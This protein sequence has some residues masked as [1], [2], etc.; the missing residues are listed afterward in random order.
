MDLP[1]FGAHVAGFEQ[2]EE[3]A[4]A[5]QV[6]HLVPVADRVQAVR[7]VANREPTPAEAWAS[8]A[9]DPAGFY[10]LLGET[11]GLRLEAA[12]DTA[13]RRRGADPAVHFWQV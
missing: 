1:H 13:P 5:E 11:I 4:V 2:A 3:H 12:A 10:S 9:A 8:F 7:E 6:G